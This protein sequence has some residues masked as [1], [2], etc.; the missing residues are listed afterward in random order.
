MKN[1]FKIIFILLLFPTLLFGQLINGKIIA[2]KPSGGTIIG[3]TMKVGALYLKQTTASQTITIGTYTSG[4][5]LVYIQNL[6]SVS[7]TLS[8]GG[9]LAVG[10]MLLYRWSGVSWS[11]SAGSGGGGSG[12]FMADGSVPMT[13]DLDA[14]THNI[15][16]VTTITDNS[17][18]PSVLANT[19]LLYDNGGNGVANWYSKSNGF[20]IR[21]GSSASWF[22]Y[23][24]TDALSTVRTWQMPDVDGTLALTSDTSLLV[25]KAGSKMTGSLVLDSSATIEAVDDL[26][27]N[28][29]HGTGHIELNAS[30]IKVMSDGITN[31]TVMVAGGTGE[32]QSSPLVVTT[33]ELDMLSGIS[34]NIQDQLNAKSD[35]GG[36]INLRNYY[37]PDSIKLATEGNI[38]LRSNTSETKIFG[39]TGVEIN[40]NNRVDINASANIALN[41]DAVELPN[42]APERVLIT[43]SSKEIN[44]S[45]T[46]KT[47]IG[48]VHNVTDSIQKQLNSKKDTAQASGK[49]VIGQ[50]YGGGLALT[51]T[52]AIT[53]NSGGDLSFN[54]YGNIFND[55]FN[56]ASVGFGTKYTQIGSTA[57][58]TINSN[59]LRVSGGVNAYADYIN[60]EQLLNGSAFTALEDYEISGT[61][62]SITAG[63]GVAIGISTVTSASI[64]AYESTVCRIDLNSS[65]NRGKLYISTVDASTHTNT[66]RINSDSALVFTDVTDQILL[67]LIRTKFTVTFIATNLRTKLSVK[68]SLVTT[69]QSGYTFHKIA[70]PSIYAVGGTQDFSSFTFS[71]PVK[72]RAKLIF[73]GDSETL[74]TGTTDNSQSFACIIS[75]ST[76]EYVAKV[77]VGSDQSS[78]LLS[79]INEPIG[80]KPQYIAFMIGTNDASK[81]VTLAAYK[82]NVDSIL[83]KITN[84]GIVPIIITPPYTT[85][86][87]TNTLLAQYIG[88][89]QGLKQ[90]YKVIDL[91]G[92]SLNNAGSLNTTYS[93]DGI[94]LTALG[95]DVI[96]KAF[97]TGTSDI[98][99]YTNNLN[100]R[101][102]P[103]SV[104]ADGTVG[105]GDTTFTSLFNIVRNSIALTPVS[106]KPSAVI[107]NNSATQGDGTTTNNNAIFNFTSE[108]GVVNGK[109]DSRSNTDSYGRSLVIGT[110]T[111]HDLIFITNNTEKVRLT[112][113]G[114]LG[115]GMTPTKSYIQIKAGTTTLAPLSFTRGALVTSATQGL[116][117]YGLN[118][119]LFFSPS[120]T[121]KSLVLTDTTVVTNGMIPI[122]ST[123]GGLF[124]SA[125]ITAGINTIITNG[126]GSITIDADTT[127]G[128]T[129]LATQGDITRAFSAPTFGYIAKTGTYTAT[130]ADYLINCTANTF[131]VTLP[132]AVGITGRVYEI[133]NSGAGTIT[134]GTTSSQTFT[135]VT[136]TPTTLTLLTAAGKAVKVMSDGAN[137]MQLY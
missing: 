36:S 44:A 27:L 111:A 32:L 47:E 21:G 82:I 117:G 53:Q 7:V 67:R 23:F 2:N 76:N 137:W 59:K 93:Y 106:G 122:G 54:E 29:T 88:Y 9:S 89:I 72:L 8:P 78:H 80:L 119:R 112:S 42:M 79:R 30:Y 108:N 101:S 120:T 16:N 50:S 114:L 110:T 19:R 116:F 41:C 22:G 115:V 68:V 26:I 136:A 105:I 103:L 102:G 46:T 86:G 35:T 98:I 99:N 18:V 95:Y 28:A 69:G 61:I 133:V 129:K 25:K 5:N 135:N 57:T 34:S 77:A 90:K 58:W 130:S 4:T 48:Y 31:G 62:N 63:N 56:R 45:A 124:S 87:P 85:S 113:A 49:I 125:T 3:D 109:I 123:S 92:T 127:N 20:G 73:T 51:A 60:A 52:G 100:A 96:A 131:T 55:N 66:A 6:G 10:G 65:G 70:K 11:V 43:N 12:D 17:N 128:S 71:T 39:Y 24:K 14:G 132:T 83:Y 1:T 64:S 94:H 126:A 121:W 74:G 84:A 81:S 134:I 37:N 15:K 40:T 97:K 104:Y 91:T 107:R 118:G 38:N 13:G 75:N 33:T